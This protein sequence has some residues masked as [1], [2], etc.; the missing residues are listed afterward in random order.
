MR[1]RAA[2][3]ADAERLG[4]LFV[5]LHVPG[6]APDPRTLI[7]DGTLVAVDDEVVGYVLFDAPSPP[8]GIIRH[9]VV[10]PRA[11]GRGLGQSLLRAAA[12]RMRAV[13][14]T[15][16]T[17][18]VRPDNAAAISVYHALGMR[19]GARLRIRA[20]AEAALA[21][22]PVEVPLVAAQADG[23]DADAPAA[24]R[25]ELRDGG[26]ALRARAALDPGPPLVTAL[27]GGPLG[28]AL[29]ALAATVQGRLLKVSSDAAE[30]EAALA[31]AGA[32]IV[33]EVVTMAGALPER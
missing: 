4:E 33:L 32:P 31:Q 27:S 21:A 1:I 11:R 20:A 12:E 7:T 10:D 28:D 16:W 5:E 13:G 18:R 3:D 19:I 29:R 24:I 30:A 2:N 8:T 23:R 25:Y 14:C 6:A 26:G 9:L 15:G 22:L 17:L